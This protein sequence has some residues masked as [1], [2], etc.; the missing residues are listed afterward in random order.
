[1]NKNDEEKK[2]PTKQNKTKIKKG[3]I[4]EYPTKLLVFVF[5][6]LVKINV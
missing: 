4:A 1:M 3:L 5:Q 2:P 6:S